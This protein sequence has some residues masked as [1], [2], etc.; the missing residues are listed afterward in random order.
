VNPS[1]AAIDVLLSVFL[2]IA[3]RFS[4]PAGVNEASCGSARVADVA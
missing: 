1:I 4:S 2:L 3:E